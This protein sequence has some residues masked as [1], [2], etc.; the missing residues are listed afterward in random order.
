ME[1]VASASGEYYNADEYRNLQLYD[2]A[3]ARVFEHQRWST[4]FDTERRTLLAVLVNK[5]EHGR[6]DRVGLLRYCL[7]E[8]DDQA[9]DD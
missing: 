1:E 9:S 7:A 4:V 8:C 3:T 5:H 2:A 6:T